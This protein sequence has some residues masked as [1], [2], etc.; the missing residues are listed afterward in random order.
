MAS[1]RFLPGDN[2]DSESVAGFVGDHVS[3]RRPL[4]RSGESQQIHS[5]YSVR[6]RGLES[7]L[8]SNPS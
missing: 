3:G 6:L 8:K 4:I 5:A 2:G 1:Y 7:L